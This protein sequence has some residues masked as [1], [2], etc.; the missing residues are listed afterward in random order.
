[1]TKMKQAPLL[2]PGNKIR[3]VA[4]A[5]KIKPERILPA[6]DWLSKQGYEVELGKHVF[7]TDYQY[8]GTDQHRLNDLQEALNDKTCAAIICARGGY[9]VVRL[10]DKIDFKAFKRNPKWLIGYSDITAL[11]LAIN[12]LD[13]ASIHGTMPPYFFDEQGNANENLTSLIKMLRGEHSNY[14]FK[15]KVPQRTGVAE[16][17]L[18]GGNLSLITSLIGTKY[19]INTHNKI[20][21]I[22][23]IDEYLY[24]IDRMMHH[25]KLAGKLENLAGLLVGDFTEI[26]DNDDPFGKTVE[27]IIWEAVSDYDFPVSF[28][29]KAGHDEKNLAL[30]FGKPC[31]LS[32]NNND[33]L[34]NFKL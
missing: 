33:S 4:P 7:A 32:V 3:I 19:E 31:T 14:T 9:G 25:L 12:N 6:A 28:G 5:G 27:E 11:H 2:K 23:D 18:I 22:E 34:I 8:A 16:A 30:A 20:L 10:L 1:M 15:T 26:K 29:L 17:Q 13:F 24:H 21:F